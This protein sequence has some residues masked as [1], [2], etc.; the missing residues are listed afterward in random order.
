VV[1]IRGPA[2]P[3]DGDHLLSLKPRQAAEDRLASV[4]SPP[5]YGRDAGPALAALLMVVREG[6][7]DALTERIIELQVSGP[8]E[9]FD[10]HS[11]RSG[12]CRGVRLE[13]PVCDDLYLVLSL[14]RHLP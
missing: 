10:A 5:G 7:Q 14:Y 3:L 13:L 12:C 9:G 6:H 11:D 8:V 2:A 4:V 1:A